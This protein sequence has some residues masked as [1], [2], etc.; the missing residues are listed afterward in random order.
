MYSKIEID[1]GMATLSPDRCTVELPVIWK[2]MGTLSGE[3]SLS[4]PAGP[5]SRYADPATPLDPPA[6]TTDRFSVARDTTVMDSTAS[7]V[8]A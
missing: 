4:L 6:E 8:Q 2:D 7:K 3:E 5:H 1:A